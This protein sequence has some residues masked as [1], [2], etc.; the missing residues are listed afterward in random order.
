MGVAAGDDE[1]EQR[2]GGG[3]GGGVLQQHRV[4]V[5]FEVVDGD[6]G[7]AEGVGQGLGVA[8]ADQQRAGEAG[9]FG[10]GDGVEVCV[11]VTPASRRAASTTGTM[12]R[13]CSREASSGTTPP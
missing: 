7:L 2:A 8:D 6:E 9:A 4:D 13:R 11:R 12:A 1:G 3:E 5:A 10:D